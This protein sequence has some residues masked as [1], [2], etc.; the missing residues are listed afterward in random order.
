MAIYRFVCDTCGQV[1]RSLLKTLDL[2]RKVS[3]SCGGILIR[4]PN[5]PSTHTK[6]ILDNGA[7][8]KSLER[9]SDAERLYKERAGK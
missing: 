1:V 4:T 9:F 7:M 2:T 6:E 3:H 5:P 8:P